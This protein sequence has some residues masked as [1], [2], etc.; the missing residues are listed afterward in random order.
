MARQEI[1]GFL[2]MARQENPGFLPFWLTF[3][4]TQLNRICLVLPWFDARKNSLKF[5]LQ[6]AM[7]EVHHGEPY[8]R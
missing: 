6:V 4:F 8:L 7:L 5:P 1:P 2:T 3:R